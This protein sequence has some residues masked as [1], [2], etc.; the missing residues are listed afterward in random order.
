[1]GWCCSASI[2]QSKSF[3][4][5]EKVKTKE[6]NFAPN[7][8]FPLQILPSIKNQIAHWTTAFRDAHTL[9]HLHTSNL[10]FIMFLMWKE[11]WWAAE[12][13]VLYAFNSGYSLCT[14]GGR[15]TVCSH[16]LLLWVSPHTWQQVTT[17]QGLKILQTT[18]QKFESIDRLSSSHVVAEPLWGLGRDEIFTDWRS[19]VC[20]L[21]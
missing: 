21:T 9:T 4:Q 2:Y 15:S 7:E 17:L 1:M 6:S 11:H 3:S 10:W 19:W 13:E 5:C 20:K 8:S 18:G 14:E 12:W 16:H